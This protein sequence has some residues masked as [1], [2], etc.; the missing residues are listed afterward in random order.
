ME[1]GT[2]K[3]LLNDYESKQ[4][5]RVEQPPLKTYRGETLANVNSQGLLL[6]IQGRH[7]VVAGASGAEGDSQKNRLQETHFGLPKPVSYHPNLIREIAAIDPNSKFLLHK[8]DI[9]WIEKGKNVTVRH[10]IESYRQ[11]TAVLSANGNLYIGTGTGGV[12]V[13]R[14]YPEQ[15]KTRQKNSQESGQTVALHFTGLQTGLPFISHDKS[16]HLYEEVRSL[17]MDQDKNLYAGLG[18]LGGLYVMKN[19]G[20][21][22]ARF[23][24][25]ELPIEN[26][27]EVYYISAAV[28]ADSGGQKVHRVWLSTQSYFIEIKT[29]FT[30]AG[31][32]ASANTPGV[33]NHRQPAAIVT[34]WEN[35]P[36][37]RIKDTTQM[38]W[39]QS[40]ED[41]RL[42]AYYK[43]PPAI[44][45]EKQKR[46]QS[47]SGKRLLYSSAYDFERKFPIIV[48]LIQN[49]AYNGLVLDI[50]DD[51]GY[52]RYDTKVEYIK[53]AGALKP[54]VNLRQ[55]IDTMK[56][57]NAYLVTRIV[58]F[59]D[60]VLYEV[61]GFPILDSRSKKPWVGNPA[62]RWVDPFN[63]ELASKYYAPLVR[64]LT[65]M[66]VNEIQLDYIRFPAEGKVDRCVYPSREGDTYFSEGVE[67][68]L[69]SIR[70]ATPLPISVDVY[71]YHGMYHSA[72][73]IGQD[74]V[75]YGKIV[76]IV[77]P[78]LYSSHFGDLYL[79]DGPLE[80]RAYRLIDFAV[81]RGV[82][83][84]E[85]S[86]LIRPYL[87]GFPM[88]TS[89][90]GYGER[91]FL[92]QIRASSQGGASGFSFWGSI[93]HMQLVNRAMSAGTK[94]PN[95]PPPAGE[96]S[97]PKATNNRQTQKNT[98]KA[99]KK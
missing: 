71:G 57:L 44:P 10:N 51:A 69:W 89:I 18:V 97:A 99:V 21:P 73:V 12:Y 76:D 30:S 25:V 17:Y 32:S 53:E 62:E 59:K 34:G 6:A 81:R 52:V 55:I 9:L 46:M 74:M 36:G 41:K 64:E 72:G 11:F 93:E 22:K 13:A 78:M 43:A 82:A 4:K 54:L 66:G 24:P 50:K 70:Q 8:H 29:S 61:P 95:V 77:S 79:T 20:S 28:S 16:I 42:Q 65:E 94:A 37:F 87:Q 45:P 60:P 58:V 40:K 38:A 27:G 56:K 39:L 67:D 90:W 2:Q 83:M 49:G 23:E 85:E 86:F 68:F 5:Y 14:N 84:A 48:S 15:I 19:A 91:Y 47:A 35:L 63:P 98:E 33:S 92:D 3:D 31:F 1:R 7:P 75:A 96:N 26:T 80:E 88:K